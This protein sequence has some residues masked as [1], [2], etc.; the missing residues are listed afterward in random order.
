MKTQ[1][2]GTKKS[3]YNLLCRINLGE[4]FDSTQQMLMALVCF[5]RLS[6]CQKLQGLQPSQIELDKGDGH[7]NGDIYFSLERRM[8]LTR[9]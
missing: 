8:P 2:L 6:Q 5:H 7:I 4:Y 1:K 3:I 9:P